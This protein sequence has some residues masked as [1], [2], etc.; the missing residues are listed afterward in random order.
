MFSCI[1]YS[2]LTA[3]MAMEDGHTGLKGPTCCFLL[4]NDPC[5]PMQKFPGLQALTNV[6]YASQW[7]QDSLFPDHWAAC[8][9]CLKVFDVLHYTGRSLRYRYSGLCLSCICFGMLVVLADLL[10]GLLCSGT[11]TLRQIAECTLSSQRKYGCD[12]VTSSQSMEG[13]SG[14]VLLIASEEGFD[15]KQGWKCRRVL[16]KCSNDPTAMRA[17]CCRI[18][19]WFCGICCRP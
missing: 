18:I 11:D 5:C 16:V 8:P 2:N 4:C 19:C 3:Y 7:M 17:D 12:G 14:G 13:M 15:L 6:M 9:F 1:R 10:H